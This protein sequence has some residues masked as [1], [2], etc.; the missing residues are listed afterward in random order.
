MTV[1]SSRPPRTRAAERRSDR[2]S[3]GSRSRRP[4]ELL[5]GVHVSTA[6]GPV[7]GVRRA[8][9]LGLNAI[10]LFT[11]S[12]RRWTPRP[13]APAE[14]ERF[15]AAR[16]EAGI[17]LAFA[18][19]SYLVRLGHCDPDLLR[20]SLAAFAA[21]LD[22]SRALGLD[23]VVTHPAAYPGCKPAE[24]LRRIADAL[25][26]IVARQGGPGWPRILLETT[27]GQGSSVFHRFE[28]VAALLEKLEPAS[29][30][31]VCVDT[32]HVFAAGYDLRT[33]R[34]YRGTWREFAAAV[35]LER[36]GLVHANDSLR[37]L[38]SRRDRHAH[39]GRG[40]LGLRAFE[41]LM[42]DR[43]LSRVPKVIET[44]KLAGGVEMD[45]VNVA[46]LRRLAA[47][48]RVALPRGRRRGRRTSRA[49]PT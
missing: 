37:G 39:I 41:L 3:G 34:A 42:R 27:A 31:G 45:P 46:T 16:A 10:Q 21:E 17:R 28:G 43:A 36:L 8:R 44:P 9:V 15:R 22:R 2:V 25:N 38:G 13:L 12:P 20:K 48:R 40:E 49:L 14:T 29:R 35:G 23:G 24:S 18:H 11:S 7:E 1:A 26:S 30:F 19:D 6:G 5:L 47:V 33:S 4:R 32:C